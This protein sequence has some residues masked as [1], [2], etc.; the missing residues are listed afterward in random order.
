MLGGNEMPCFAS[1]SISIIKDWVVESHAKK[2]VSKSPGLVDFPL[3]LVN[4]V[5][6]LPDRQVMFFEQFEY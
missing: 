2:V 6:K 4:S 5:V 1:S 3:G